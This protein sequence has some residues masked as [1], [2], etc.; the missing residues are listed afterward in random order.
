MSCGS[1][2][3]LTNTQLCNKYLEEQ[4]VQ[5]WFKAWMPLKFYSDDDDLELPLHCVETDLYNALKA[6]VDDWREDRQG[7]VF[8]YYDRPESGKT[9]AAKALIG[10]LKRYMQENNAAQYSTLYVATARRSLRASMREKLAI[11]TSLPDPA[12]LAM[13][14]RFL[15]GEEHLLALKEGKSWIGL[16]YGWHKLRSCCTAQPAPAPPAGDPYPNEIGSHPP[17]IVLDDVMIA[18]EKDEAYLRDIYQL[19]ALYRVLVS[20]FTDSLDMANFMAAMNGQRRVVPLPGRFTITTG[21]DK[22]TIKKKPDIVYPGKLSESAVDI[23]WTPEAWTRQTQHNYV[24]QFYPDK[25]TPDNLGPDG[26]FRFLVDGDIPPVALREADRY[27][28]AGPP[29]QPHAN[30]ETR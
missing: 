7:S 6:T 22:Y 19:A 27:F 8:V 14:F 16:R 26:C 15:K 13:V 10:R 21:S 5:E 24:L 4:G 12:G 28:R 1:A 25:A 18:D 2:S 17:V 9:V 3:D 11:P 20:V 23:V 30:T 29:Q